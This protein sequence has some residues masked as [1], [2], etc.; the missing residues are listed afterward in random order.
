MLGFSLVF[1][2]VALPII[3]VVLSSLLVAHAIIEASDRIAAAIREHSGTPEGDAA[4]AFT[5]EDLDRM[6]REANGL[7][8]E[9]PD[10]GQMTRGQEGA[11]ALAGEQELQPFEGPVF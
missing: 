9:G 4:Q 5:S 10:D 6:W 7:P 8:A 2:A 3:V 1:L 11:L